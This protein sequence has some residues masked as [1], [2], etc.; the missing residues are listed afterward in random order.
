MKRQLLQTYGS[1]IEKVPELRDLLWISEQAFIRMSEAIG[2]DPKD[3]KTVGSRVI[4]SQ[5]YHALNTSLSVRILVTNGQVLEA[6]ALLRMRLEQVIVSSLLI[7][8]PIED[9]FD[10]FANDIG[11]VDYRAIQ[12]L[13][14]T[15]ALRN[16]IEDLLGHKFIQAEGAAIASEIADDPSFDISTGK[17]KRK[18]TDLNTYDMAVRRDKLVTAKGGISTRLTWFYAALYKSS[19]ILLHADAGAI[20]SNY[21]SQSARKEP[22]PQVLYLLLAACRIIQQDEIVKIAA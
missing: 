20:S 17:I 19:S 10:K 7:H 12:S 8:S 22:V 16:L 9:G 14:K 11:R 3:W 1:L 2:Q 18:W 13:D 21:L 6:Y 15:P 5:M 4:Q